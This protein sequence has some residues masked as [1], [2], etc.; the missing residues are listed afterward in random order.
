[1]PAK[2]QPNTYRPWQ[3]LIASTDPAW[4][5]TAAELADSMGRHAWAE[6]MRESA[7]VCEEAQGEG[8]K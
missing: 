4:L 7:N 6:A 3:E 1:M 2:Y 5:R 8:S